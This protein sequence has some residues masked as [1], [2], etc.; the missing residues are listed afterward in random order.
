MPGFDRTG[1][2]GAGPMTGGA[3]GAC[4]GFGRRGAGNRVANVGFTGGGGGGRGRRN[5][6]ARL[7]F[8][9]QTFEPGP[10]LDAQPVNQLE[11]LKASAGYFERILEGIRQRI[12]KLES[13]A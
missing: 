8:G 2:S 3:R 11:T 13:G 7:G 1:P 12:Q 10:A 4:T 9:P 5:R 6:F